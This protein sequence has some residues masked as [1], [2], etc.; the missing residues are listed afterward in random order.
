[1][2][3]TLLPFPETI[4]F[5]CPH[6]Q[7][8]LSVPAALAGV[9]GPCPMCHGAITAPALIEEEVMPPA[10]PALRVSPPM[11]APERL[12]Q[13]AV[14]APRQPLAIQLFEKRGFRL[15]RTSLAA[16]STIVLFASFAALKSRRWIWSPTE[17]ETAPSQV[18]FAPAAA[19]APSTTMPV[20][21]PPSNLQAMRGK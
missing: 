17:A 5:A 8:P 4:E 10:T 16:A 12:T 2:A 21:P 14:A 1:M 13:A 19:P 6:C 15:V 3:T 20:E 11:P 7:A 9:S 18:N